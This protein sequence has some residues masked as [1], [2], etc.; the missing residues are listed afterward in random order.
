MRVA[1]IVG[2]ILLLL[3]AIVL[4]ANGKELKELGR[5]SQDI[6]RPGRINILNKDGDIIYYIEQDRIRPTRLIIYDDHGSEVGTIQPDPIRPG[7][8]LFKGTSH[9]RRF[10]D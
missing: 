10:N 3:L 5:T 8:R 9:F 6:I 4:S 1:C 7:G 2:F